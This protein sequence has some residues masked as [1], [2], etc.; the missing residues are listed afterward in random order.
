MILFFGDSC[1]P[2]L[3]IETWESGARRILYNQGTIISVEEDDA[4]PTS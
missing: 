1:F 2:S 4:I 3:K